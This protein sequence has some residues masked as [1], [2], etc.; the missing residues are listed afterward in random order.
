MFLVFPFA[1]H[2]DPVDAV[3]KLVLGW[4]ASFVAWALGGIISLCI[5]AIIE[6]TKYNNFVNESSIKEAWAIIR[7]ISN[8]FFIL[9]LLL[10]AFATILRIETYNM[11]RWLPKL[12][13]MAVLINFSK[14]I[15]GIMID[16]SQVIMLT[17]VNTFATNGG[18]FVSYLKIKEFI[19]GVQSSGK[20][21][22]DNSIDLTKVA[23]GYVVAVIFM[24]VACV[25][26]ISILVV[27]M[28]RMI[29]LWI[30]IVLSPLAFMLS[31]FPQGQRYASQYWGEFT[32]YLINGP[33]LAFF[34]WL[35][36]S[37]INSLDVDTFSGSE[38]NVGLV[39][40]VTQIM[41]LQY[42]IPF[43]LS[44][45]FLAGGLMISRQIGGAGASW[46]SSTVSKLG[47]KGLNMTKRAALAPLKA[48]GAGAGALASFGVDKLHQ[49]TGVDLNAK[50]VWSGIKDKRAERKKD[51]YAEGMQVAADV[52][53]ERGGRLYGAL[54]MTGTPGTGWETITSMK[55]LKQRFKGGKNMAVDKAR[56]A[57]E[58]DQAKFE[59]DFVSKSK[60]DRTKETQ[61]MTKRLVAL[62]SEIAAE[63][64][65]M[66]KSELVE[67]RE[68]LNK[69]RSFAVNEHNYS[70]DFSEDEIKAKRL[71]VDDLQTQMN[72]NI[73]LYDFEA[74]AAEQSAVNG[75]MSKIS[76]ITDADE[77]NRILDTAIEQKDKTMIKATGRKMAMNGDENEFLQ[78][79]A[80]RTDAEGL[81]TYV[82]ALSGEKELIKQ[83][84][85]LAKLAKA[86][87]TRQE[88]FAFGSEIS[89]IAKNTNHWAATGAFKMKNGSWEATSKQ[90]SA[91]YRSVEVG[92]MHLQNIAR[93]LNR[94]AYGHHDK[95]GVFHLDE[96]GIMAL[97]KLDSE[98]GW[99]Q[100]KDNMNESAVKYLDPHVDELFLQGH[101][102]NGL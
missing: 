27:F 97:K 82:R 23:V 52:M 47:N 84:P 68:V 70:R 49:K 59:Q 90:E 10:I 31:S 29:M 14:T 96:A 46:G 64:D 55:G 76:N 20:T 72:S 63:K 66:K 35:A 101:I 13:I 43:V 40:G 32:K 75:K 5:G 71:R 50:R 58:L 39:A 89:N 26:M 48:T 67:E 42:F 4:L 99:K 34:I 85:E 30:F 77:L 57:P 37:T 2:A 9:I 78:R 100:A 16:F 69:R 102:S 28:M 83:H 65:E 3:L 11:K 54:A 93:S 45:G 74:R 18:D 8:M 1:C 80:G 41:T 36:L 33:V 79:L 86:G 98:G 15:C 62:D 19:S 22:G 53:R 51:R 91:L 92:K 7:D 95:D 38:A 44:I 12:L 73:P 88:A 25:A 56:L 61:K 94:L 17:F 24:L 6:V 87:F 21:W 60:K 81:Q